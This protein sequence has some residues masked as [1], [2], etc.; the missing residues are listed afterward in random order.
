[1]SSGA[2]V[3]PEIEAQLA[4]A[5][6]KSP[7]M[8][9]FYACRMALELDLGRQLTPEEKSVLGSVVYGVYRRKP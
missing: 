5:L 8:I 6:N 9:R 1:M 3:M 7:M 4:E 2:I